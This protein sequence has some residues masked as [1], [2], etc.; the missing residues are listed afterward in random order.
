MTLHVVII[1]I[2]VA[3]AAC[4]VRRNGIRGRSS[5]G[6]ELFFQFLNDAQIIII[7]LCLRSAG[8]GGSSR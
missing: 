1:I 5:F 7:L 4:F 8:G 2:E 3:V 6:G